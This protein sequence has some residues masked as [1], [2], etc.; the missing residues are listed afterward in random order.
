M[1]ESKLPAWLQ[2]SVDPAKVSLTIKGLVVF[3]P[4]IVL[5]AGYFGLHLAPETVTEGITQLAAALSAGATVW[6]LFRKLLTDPG[7]P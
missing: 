2:S 5:L 6:G 7:A 3:V 4:A 1:A